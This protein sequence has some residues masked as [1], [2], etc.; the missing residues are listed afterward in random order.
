MTNLINRSVLAAVCGVLL[1]A[2][3]SSA[4]DVPLADKVRHELN[5]LPY[6]GVFDAITYEVNGNAVT[7]GGAVHYP[8]LASDAVNVV[9]SIPGVASVS[10]QIEV[11]P[12]SRFDDQIRLAA[13][14][15]VYSW[16]TMSRVASMPLPPV[17][18][19]VKNG[20]ITLVGLVPS[21]ADKDALNLRVNG[22]PNVFSVKNELVVENPPTRRS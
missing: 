22:I 21:Q 15:T 3:S 2:G 10:N 11:L 18:I 4:K 8:V 13:W 14:R 12:V 7:L 17:R 9:K 20:D 6:Y 5:M 16:P 19:L 1:V